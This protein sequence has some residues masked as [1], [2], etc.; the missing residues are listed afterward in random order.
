M[1]RYPPEKT[2]KLG[3][4]KIKTFVYQRTL[5]TEWK[6]GWK[7][8]GKNGWNVGWKKIFSNH[9]YDKELISRMHKNSYNST[10]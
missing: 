6:V 1:K 8:Y 2:H 10:T 7:K 4:I 3:F 9:I 5:S